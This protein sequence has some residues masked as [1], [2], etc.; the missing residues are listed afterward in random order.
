MSLSQKV[1]NAFKWSFLKTVVGQFFNPLLRL[2]AIPFIGDFNYG[3][4][5]IAFLYFG[6]L[7]TLLGIGIRDF[8]IS[9][10]INDKKKLKMLNSISLIFSITF[11]GLAFIL[12]PLISKVYD[13]NTIATTFLFICF[14]LP[15]IGIGLVP[16]AIAV[17]NLDMKNVFFIYLIPFMTSLLIVLPLAINGYGLSAILL[18]EVLNRILINL[19][20]VFLNPVGFSLPNKRFSFKIFNF[21]KWIAGERVLE[22]MSLTID[23]FFISFLGPSV[24]GVYNLGKNII[25]I[26]FTVLNEPLGNI[27]MSIFGIL[28][29]SY[30]R[31]LSLF[32]NILSLNI[33]LNITIAFL[34]SIASYFFF[35]IFLSDWNNLN[36][37]CSY[38]FIGG[39]FR[40]SL[41]LQ[42]D[43]LKTIKKVKF[44][45]IS[46][47]ASLLVYSAFYKL[48][49]PSNI[50]SFL[51]IKI[52]YDIS[53]FLVFA[54]IMK[55]ILKNEEKIVRMN[56]F[57]INAVMLLV[58]NSSFIFLSIE[59]IKELSLLNLIFYC[60]IIFLINVTIS[61]KF[62]VDTFK[63]V[64]MNN[65]NR[66]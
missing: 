50:E 55:N 14:T 21:S 29:E 42:R 41:W 54:I 40:R 31:I 43:F 35:T 57:I 39:L 5:A 48:L 62:F 16:E 61:Y 22:Y 32:L 56:K 37:V 1:K 28:K 19:C 49:Q 65:I 6:L 51:Q 12:F 9:Q 53:Y 17:R 30:S 46:I 63:K 26:V 2:V 60:L 59:I 10:S 7:E 23:T 52:I 3:I 18:G 20:Y 24:A 64:Q 15:F 27:M 58:I 45:P 4:F 11:L 47:F 34:G 38:L 33:S 66:I 36:I 44:Y 13:S 8:I 25:N